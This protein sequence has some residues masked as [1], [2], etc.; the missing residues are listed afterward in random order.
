MISFPI[1]LCL[2]CVEKIVQDGLIMARGLS[3]KLLEKVGSNQGRRYWVS[4]AGGG[5]TVSQSFTPKVFK[6]RENSGKL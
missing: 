5:V 6:Y 1:M 4:V 3:L 2:Y